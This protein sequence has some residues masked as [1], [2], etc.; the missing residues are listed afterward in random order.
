MLSDL[1]ESLRRF[2]SYRT[3]LIGG[4]GESDIIIY[5]YIYIYIYIHIYLLLQ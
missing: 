3:S 5:I 1:Q 4:T 2:F